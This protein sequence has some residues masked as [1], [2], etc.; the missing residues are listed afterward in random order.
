MADQ[1]LETEER[2]EEP[3]SKTRMIVIVLGLVA[4]AAV[5][6]VLWYLKSGREVYTDDAFIDA[7]K[8]TISSKY[9][10]RVASLAA[11]E[12]ANVVS[13]QVIAILDT[14]DLLAQKE[15]AKAS[16]SFAQESSKLAKVNLS[17]AEEDFQRVEA[18]YKNKIVAKEQY[19]HAKKAFQSAKVQDSIAQAQILTSQAQLG[20]IE[21]QLGNAEIKAPMD[22]VV[23]KKWVLSGDVVTA[24]QAIYTVYDIKNVWIAANLEETKFSQLSVGQ[25]ADI[26]VDAYG[27]MKLRGKVSQLGSNTA[28]QFSLIPSSNASGNFTKVTQRIPIK[29]TPDRDLLEKNPG[30]LLPGMSVE[31]LVKSK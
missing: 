9:S 4:V 23:A 11:S 21:T 7:D 1:I 14:S 17:K 28:S 27:G 10:G 30:K 24:G 22:G 8:A 5:L 31:V 20:V 29:I 25:T 18:Q 26:T 6:Y 3:S 2:G 12:G 15:Q 16:V 13:G 19:D